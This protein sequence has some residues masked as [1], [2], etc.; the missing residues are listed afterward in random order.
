[1]LDTQSL[2][3]RMTYERMKD[4]L[5]AV[6]RECD[7]ILGRFEVLGRQPTAAEREARRMAYLANRARLSE[8]G[9]RLLDLSRL[10]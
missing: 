10:L 8:V 4:E 5:A 9:N 1:M 7:E 6:E 3:R 2:E